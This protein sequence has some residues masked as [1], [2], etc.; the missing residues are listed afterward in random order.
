MRQTPRH[1]APGRIALRLQQR[2]DVIEHQHHA[3]GAAGVIGQ[4]RA[5]AHQHMLAGLGQQLD[6][7]A[8]VE[9][10]RLQ[11]LLDGAQELREQR[12]CR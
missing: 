1:L 3:R 9:L 8:P 5:G 10:L 11:P 4:R 2:G 7:F 6:L 12:R